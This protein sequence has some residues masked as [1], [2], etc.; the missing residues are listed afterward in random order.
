ML[1]KETPINS[2][3]QK[4]LRK[5]IRGRSNFQKVPPFGVVNSCRVKLFLLPKGEKTSCLTE[6][7]RGRY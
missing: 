7:F 1:I 5:G 4:F 3:I 6:Y 2:I